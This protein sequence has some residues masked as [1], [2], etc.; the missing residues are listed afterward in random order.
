MS[1]TFIFVL[2]SIA[3]VVGVVAQV[4]LTPHYSP[5]PKE[6]EIA[7][8]NIHLE[9]KDLR[10]ALVT[11]IKGHQ[12]VEQASIVKKSIASKYI[13]DLT[14]LKDGILAIKVGLP[15]KESKKTLAVWVWFI[16]VQDAQGGV[17]WTCVAYPKKSLTK[18][19][20]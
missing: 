3:L 6:S 11:A 16:P 9:T 14:V 1:R 10:D 12:S 17:D 20:D 4:F 19:C 13:E 15:S 5:A 7:L 18:Q 2:I 8:L